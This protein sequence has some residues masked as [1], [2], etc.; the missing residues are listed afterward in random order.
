VFV[1]A[2]TG[3]ALNSAVTVIGLISIT[4]VIID[5]I[6]AYVRFHFSVLKSTNV[7]VTWHDRYAVIVKADLKNDSLTSGGMTS[8]SR[9]MVRN[10]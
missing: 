5:T 8:I 10:T 3:H 2:K 1:L 4:T 7:I 9:V 6:I